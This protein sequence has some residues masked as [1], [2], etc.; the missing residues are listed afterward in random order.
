MKKTTVYLPDGLKAALERS[1]ITERR[2]E[3]ELIREA[4]AEKLEGLERPRPHVPLSSEGLG[5]PLAAERVDDLLDGFGH[6]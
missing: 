3:A 5:D 1:A 6:R 4:I 2:S